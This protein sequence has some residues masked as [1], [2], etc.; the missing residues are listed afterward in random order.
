VARAFRYVDVDDVWQEV[1]VPAGA[2]AYTWCQVPVVYRLRDA[3]RSSVTVTLQD[4]GTQTLSQSSL[5]ADLARELYR[6]SGRVRQIV[7][8]VPAD[9]LLRD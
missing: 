7:V 9:S 8:D 5:P 4:G 1:E 2:L 6:R 3:G